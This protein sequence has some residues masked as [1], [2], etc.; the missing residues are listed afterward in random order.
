GLSVS[1]S[2]VKASEAL[3]NGVDRAM[4]D[5]IVKRSEACMRYVVTGD[6]SAF[7]RELPDPQRQQRFR[8]FLD[9]RRKEGEPEL[10][11][12]QGG[13]A[14]TVFP[15]GRDFADYRVNVRVRLAKGAA[16]VSLYWKGTK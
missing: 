16:V 3:L 15:A 7:T 12:P 2:S 1:V 9:N 14:T 4:L 8:S 13:D 11:K 5:T 10:G 6:F